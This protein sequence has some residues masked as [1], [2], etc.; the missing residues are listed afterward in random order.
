MHLATLVTSSQEPSKL[1]EAVAETS[2]ELLTADSLSISRFEASTAILR[3]LINVGDVGVGE[4]RWPLNETYRVAD[5]PDTLGFL[6]DQPV[7][8]VATTVD[9]PDAEPAEVALLQSVGK[10]SSLKAAIIVD[11]SVW[12]ELW[13]ARATAGKPFTE[14]DADLAD[15]IS[16]LISAGLAQASA[17]QRL[18]SLAVTDSLTGLANRR[19]MDEHLR[20]HVARCEALELPLAV[21]VADVNGLKAANDTYGHAAGDD[22]IKL[23]ASAAGTLAADVTDA[24]AARLGGDEFVLILPAVDGVRAAQIGREWANA[25]QHPVFNTSIAVGIAVTDPAIVT[26]GP[27]GPSG[28]SRASGLLAR[29]DQAQYAAKRAGL[30]EPLLA[31][32]TNPAGVPAR[33]A[34]VSPDSC[35]SDAE[36]VGGAGEQVAVGCGVEHASGEMEVV[37]GVGQRI[38]QRLSCAAGGGDAVPPGAEPLEHLHGGQVG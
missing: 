34:D 5:F 31:G 18:H 23:V 7:R 27:D 19:A 29:A 36:P 25:G 32:A 22:A 16:A 33:Q 10:W 26:H 37:G 30:T 1:I 38:V 24:L 6:T 17:W 15:V 21:L 4:Q 12:G 2:K 28:H 14:T 11:G 3:T 13:A 35:S 8:H 20:R 9:D